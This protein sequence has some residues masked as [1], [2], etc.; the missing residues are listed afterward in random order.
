MRLFESGIA[1][2][3]NSPGFTW[4]VMLVAESSHHFLLVV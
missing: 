3:A 1:M 2:A 4:A